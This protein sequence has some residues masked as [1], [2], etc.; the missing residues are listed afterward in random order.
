V[1]LLV[2]GWLAIGLLVTLVVIDGERRPLGAWK[3]IG[4]SKFLW[5]VLPV[6]GW[7]VG[8]VL[9][10]VMG[11]KYLIS[12]RGQLRAVQ[13]GLDSTATI[14]ANSATIY[15]GTND[16]QKAERLERAVSALF[17][18]Y[19]LELL[20]VGPPRIGSWLR[21]FWIRVLSG[22]L[23]DRLTLLEQALHALDASGKQAATIGALITAAKEIDDCVILSGR[24]LVIKARRL[25]AGT[26]LYARMLT[27]AEKE[28]FDRHPNLLT[29]PET[30]VERLHL[31]STDQVPDTLPSGWDGKSE[32]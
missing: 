22:N 3:S 1:E 14:S 21:Q 17:V 12:I 16:T 28:Q 13:A 30:V 9:G 20:P 10:L 11:V 24:L 6:F 25:D 18:A 29:E 31:L 4:H 26:Y 23:L 2:V 5:T 8:G 27:A 32:P 7:L 15:L 19:G